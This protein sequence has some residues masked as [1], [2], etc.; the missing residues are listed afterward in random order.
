MKKT[1]FKTLVIAIIALMLTACNAA[2]SESAT[3]INDGGTLILSVN[4]E[5]KI[6]YD[7]NGLVEA[8]EGVNDDGKKIV[9]DFSDYIGKEA[10]TV[11]SELVTKIGAAGYFV[12]EV[13]GERKQVIIEIEK[14]SAIP[15][16]GFIDEVVN[17]VKKAT[18]TNRWYSPIDV[19]N[20]TD[21]GYTHY[22][23][24]DYGDGNDSI[25]DYHDTDYGPD[26]DGVTDYHDTD[27][28]YHNDS[29]TDYDQNR[30]DDTDY[31]PYSD[32]VTDYADTDY[33]PTNDGVTDYGYTNYGDGGDSGYDASSDYSGSDYG[34]SDYD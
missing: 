14:G 29:I 25:T 6:C 13:E 28:G 12:E 31:G 5:I 33:G 32:G 34:N 7:E 3:T 21:Y 10:R 16:D 19:R 30:V 26:N 11:V 2:P 8:V 20:E 22:I 9:E 1:L 23:D 24:T 18:D 27:Y 4:P 15:Y 17:D